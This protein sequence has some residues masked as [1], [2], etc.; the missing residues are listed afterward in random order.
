M[1]A[2]LNLLRKPALMRVFVSQLLARFPLGMLSMGILIFIQSTT[3]Q[4]GLAGIIVGSLS[5]GEAV[6]VPLTSRLSTRF[7]TRKFLLWIGIANAIAIAAL[8]IAPHSFAFYVVIALVAGITTPPFAAVSRALF[9]LLAD[10]EETRSL[11]ALDTAAQE[12][13]WIIGPVLAAV[14]AGIYPAAPLL[15]CSAFTVAGTLWFV[16]SPALQTVRLPLSQSKFGY[17]LKYKSLVITLL[18]MFVLV[19]S[20]TSFEVGLLSYF[21]ADAFWMGMAIALSG[22]GSLTGALLLGNKK[23]GLL[24]TIG[25]LLITALGTTAFL[26]SSDSPVLFSAAL[27][28]SGFGF[29]PGIASLLLMVSHAVR[30]EDS[31]EAFGWIATAA[32]LGGACGTALGGFTTDAYDFQTTFAIAAVLAFASAGVL[33]ISRT[34]GPVPGLSKTSAK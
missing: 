19:A 11:F 20:W 28:V 32:L 27:F 8:V 7:D 30:S 14:S 22:A 18:V 2:Y 24:S 31:A 9:P 16:T 1:G 10:E 13:L 26:F 21:E 29:A 34:A 5:I 33:V 15:L 25:V 12:I 17:V 4:Y 6:M 23:L 3:Q